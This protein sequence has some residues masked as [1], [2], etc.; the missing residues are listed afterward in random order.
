MNITDVLAVVV[1]AFERIRMLNAD[2]PSGTRVRLTE[3]RRDSIVIQ[4]QNG[5][6]FR[7]TVTEEA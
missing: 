4:E 5:K 1:G 7:I 3:V 2:N 6:K